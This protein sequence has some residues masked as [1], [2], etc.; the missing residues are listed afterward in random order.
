M[1]VLAYT[2]TTVVLLVGVA[3]AT[4][5]G[6]KNFTDGNIG[7]GAGMAC[8]ITIVAPFVALGCYTGIDYAT[9]GRK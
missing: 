6:F 9:K 5:I 8:L 3:L 4:F 1:K 7:A 2:V